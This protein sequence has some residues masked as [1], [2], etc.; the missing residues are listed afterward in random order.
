MYP[1]TMLRSA[2]PIYQKIEPNVNSHGD[3]IKQDITEALPMEVEQSPKSSHPSS[4]LVFPQHMHI[5]GD[6]EMKDLSMPDTITVPGSS[7]KAHQTAPFSPLFLEE[8]LLNIPDEELSPCPS[9]KD[10]Y[11]SPGDM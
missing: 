6:I 4:R 2:K 10:V 3:L 1:E 9:P 8:E 7:E 11:P 5:D